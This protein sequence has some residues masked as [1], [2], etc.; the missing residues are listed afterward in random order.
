VPAG[1]DV[2]SYVVAALLVAVAV[3]VRWM[4]RAWFGD[5]VCPCSSSPQSCPKHA[6]TTGR[7]DAEQPGGL[8]QREFQS[9]HFA[10][11]R[12]NARAQICT[13]SSATSPMRL[14]CMP[15]LDAPESR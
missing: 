12:L 4:F 15:Q 13:A 9:Q 8:R 11:L 14:P 6:L 7:L 3:V 2:R 5:T 10:E 1:G